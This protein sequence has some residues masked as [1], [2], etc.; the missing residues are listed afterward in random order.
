[1]FQGKQLERLDKN[2]IT[3]IKYHHQQQQQQPQQPSAIIIHPPANQS[4]YQPINRRTNQSTNESINQSIKHHHSFPA[5]PRQASLP[6]GFLF[7]KLPP[8]LCAELLVYLTTTVMPP[9]QYAYTISI[10]LHSSIIIH[11]HCPPGLRLCLFTT[12]ASCPPHD[13]SPTAKRR[14]EIV[15]YKCSAPIT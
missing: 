3:I 4:I 15:L 9:A 8:P 14:E 13:P 11:A 7:C 6:V 10:H 2:S 5:D 1:M 12:F